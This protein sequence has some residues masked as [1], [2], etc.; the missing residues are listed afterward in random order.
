MA[1]AVNT[2][3]GKNKLLGTGPRL[4]VP[5]G[6]RGAEHP[7]APAPWLLRPHVPQGEGSMRD[8]WK[9]GMRPHGSSLSSPLALSHSHKP[10]DPIPRVGQEDER[11]RDV[12]M[13]TEGW[14]HR[15]EPPWA[16]PTVLEVV[17]NEGSRHC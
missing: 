13:A 9:E 15:L 10:T 6:V 8:G 16:P 2:K 14:W 5:T 3:P 7:W 1:K 17:E 4:G 12:P 11:C